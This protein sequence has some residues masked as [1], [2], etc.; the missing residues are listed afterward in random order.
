LIKSYAKHVHA[1]N[2]LKAKIKKNDEVFYGFTVYGETEAPQSF[3]V[4]LFELQACN[5]W[6][7]SSTP[8]FVASG[9]LFFY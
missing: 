3:R 8:A 4:Y 6:S 2:S 5:F 1:K 9:C 7:F